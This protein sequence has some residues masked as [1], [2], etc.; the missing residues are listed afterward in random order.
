MCLRIERVGCLRDRCFEGPT[1]EGG[2]AEVRRDRTILTNH[3]EVRD[4]RE[5]FSTPPWTR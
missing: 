5:T 1:V 3:Q 2:A 4:H